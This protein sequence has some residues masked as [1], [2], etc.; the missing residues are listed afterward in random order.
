MSNEKI[1][2]VS[3]SLEGPTGFATNA[4]GVAW[5]LAKE[6]DV[7][8]LGLQSLRE[9][10]VSIIMEGEERHVIQHPNLPRNRNSKWDFG[11]RSLPVLLDNLEPDILLTVNDIQMVQHIPSVLCP[12]RV[13]LK[14][15]DLPSKKF[16]SPEAIRLQ[17]EGEIE[18]FR[19][20]YPR[21][22]KW[23]ALCFTPDTEILTPEGIKNIKDV[24]V[25]DYVYSWNPDTKFMEITRVI[26]KQKHKYN[27]ELISIKQKWVDFKVTPDHI[28]LMNG[29]KMIASDFLDIGKSVRKRFPV[30]KGYVPEDKEWFD[31]YK[32]FDDNYIIRIPISSLSEEEKS[33]LLIAGWKVNHSDNLYFL[34]NK[35]GNVDSIE[36]LVN[37]KGIYAKSSARNGENIPL[38]VKLSD[39]LSLSGWYISEGYLDKHTQSIKMS[40]EK[41]TSYRVNIS[42]IN[43]SGRN[44]IKSLLE[45]MN[46]K[47]SVTNNRISITGRFYYNLFKKLFHKYGIGAQILVALGVK[48]MR[49]LTNNPRKIVGLQGFGLEVT[50]R[51]PIEIEP[52]A[53]NEDYLRAKAEKLGHLLCCK[54]KG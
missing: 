31:F 4:T 29:K 38:R 13:N 30:N 37:I 54:Y 45:R 42:Q 22:V 9:N 25:G 6:F 17:L 8:V 23:V 36:N 5:S 21:D 28:F 24:N 35:F 46:I 16:L 14:L 44:K 1:L 10:K 41:Y 2:I 26:D 48:K 32:Y 27:G 7:H 51:V 34:E 53:Y 50:E 40:G 3:D 18:K 43:T 47:F 52:N 19:E 39:F 12:D 20:K 49:L 11:T 33:K 15:I